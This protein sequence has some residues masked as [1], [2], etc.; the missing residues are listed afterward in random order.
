MAPT[1]SRT[2]SSRTTT[3][4]RA[5][6]PGS[7]GGLDRNV[8]L[9]HGLAVAAV[10]L[11]AWLFVVAL[12][13][14][15]LAV[16]FQRSFWVAGWRIVHGVSAYH[17]TRAEGF[18]SVSFPYPAPA[19][20]FFAPWS[21]VSRSVSDSLFALLS[22]VAAMGALRLLEVRDWR[23]YAAAALWQPIVLGWQTGNTTLLLL[24]GIAAVWRWRDEPK[25]AGVVLGLMLAFKPTVWPLVVWLGATRRYSAVVTAIGI[26]ALCNVIGWAVLGFGEIHSWLHLVSRQTAEEFR[27][28][29]GLLAIGA[30]VGIGRST[31]TAIEVVLTAMLVVGVA[32]AARGRREIE[33]VTLAIAAMVTSSPI[34]DSHYFALLTVPIV[35]VQ[36]RLAP[37]TFLP[38][39][40]WLCPARDAAAWQTV[41]PWLVTGCVLYAA[42]AMNAQVAKAYE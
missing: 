21:L 25:L 13:K 11:T 26:A 35:L 10:G 7:G 5:P 19:G 27:S 38:V 23:V 41:V 15:I 29:Y 2:S 37:L 42:Y 1:R 8:A 33:A 20:L 3:S 4:P 40:M 24:A 30:H 28:G 9:E 16:D 36:R 12:H 6:L 39:V 18:P 17:W 32:V 31:G 34:V 22:L 14:N